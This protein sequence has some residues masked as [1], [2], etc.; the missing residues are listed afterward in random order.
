MGVIDPQL[1]VKISGLDTR[2][3]LEARIAGTTPYS[4]PPRCSKVTVVTEGHVGLVTVDA[5]PGR[6][7]EVALPSAI[8]EPETIQASSHRGASPPRVHW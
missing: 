8:Q 5:L 3:P 4:F 7:V 2:A 6:Q 1:T